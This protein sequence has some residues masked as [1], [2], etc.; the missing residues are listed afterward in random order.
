MTIVSILQ[1]SFGHRQQLE[2]SSAQL[3]I[4]MISTLSCRNLFIQSLG[5]K[6][7]L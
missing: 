5:D 1:L 2:N 6:V 7:A 4:A 3:T